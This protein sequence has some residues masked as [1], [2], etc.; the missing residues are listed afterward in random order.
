MTE[1]RR[2]TQAERSAATRK[3]LLDATIKCLREHGYGATTTMMV[4]S[5]AMVSRGAML[6]QFPTKADLMTFIVEA[7]HEEA[8]LIYSSL[9]SDIVEPRERTIGY[10]KAVWAVESR[11]AGI[12]VLE[13]LQGS[14]SDP[15]L[16][17]KLAPVQARIE[18]GALNVLSREFRNPS[19]TLMNL[20][21]GAVRGLSIM[22]VIKP[23][24]D[25]AAAIELLQRLLRAGIETGTISNAPSRKSD[26]AKSAKAKARAA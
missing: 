3:L 4:A 25:A 2:R 11:P 21:V 17:A 18:A 20:I 12:A 7:A 9:L 1:Q 15:E 24:N 19:P 23:E 14:R 5:R 10:P 13:I 22:Q 8:I 16:A 6:H 26:T